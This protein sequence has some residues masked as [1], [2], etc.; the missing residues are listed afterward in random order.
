MQTVFEEV[1]EGEGVVYYIETWF[2]AFDACSEFC[3][4]L[5]QDFFLPK[6]SFFQ[7]QFVYLASYLY[8]KTLKALNDFF[9]CHLF[10]KGGRVTLSKCSRP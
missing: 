3:L 1:E 7:S 9:F 2:I 10:L 6:T 4:M 8:P 5:M